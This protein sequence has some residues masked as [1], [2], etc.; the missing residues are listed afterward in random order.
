MILHIKYHAQVLQILHDG[1]GQQGMERTIALYREHFY[2]NT[3]YKDET[4]YVN[5][6]PHCKEAKGHYE[7]SKTKPGSIIAI[8]PLDLLYVDFRKMD[9]SRDSKKDVLILTDAI[10]KLSLAFVTSN[11][12][13]LSMAKLIVNK[14][15]YVCGVLAHIHSDKGQS[16]ENEILE[17]LYTLCS[18]QPWP[19]AHMEIPSVRGLTIH[20]MTY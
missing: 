2:W 4:E 6:F 18:P 1:Q 11:P 12:K 3:M 17:H 13:D 20:S 19:T 8:R 5:N 15:F 7:G 16:F 9:P 14:W 10:S